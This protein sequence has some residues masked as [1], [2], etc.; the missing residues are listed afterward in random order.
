MFR[1]ESISKA[2]FLIKPSWSDWFY[3]MEQ[4]S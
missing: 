4:T 1:A 3:N 2:L